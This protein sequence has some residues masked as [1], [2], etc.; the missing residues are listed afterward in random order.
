MASKEY[1]IWC[2]ESIKKGEFY[3]N[4]YGGVLIQSK[5]VQFVN[6]ALKKIVDEIKITEEIKWGK[7]DGV[8]LKAF[9]TLMDVFFKLVQKN[10]IKVRIMFRQNAKV[11]KNL[12]QQ[13]IENEFFLLYYQFIKHAFGLQYSNTTKS[14]IHV[15]VHFDNLPDTISKAQQFKDYIKGL[16]RVKSFLD[17]KIKFRKEGIVEVDSKLHLPLQFLDVVLGSMQFRL[18]DKHKEKP[19]GK[20]RRG[21]RTIAKE[22]LYKHINKKIRE[23]RKGF[24]VGVSTGLANL[25]ERWEHPYRHWSF[26]PK[27]FE[28]EETLNK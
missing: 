10:K 26:T 24:N 2:D 11:A 16:E 25:N 15:R 6:T 13:H 22:K 28:I 7:V 23:T 4:F 18:N 8:K 5:D 12:Q 3:S 9:I 20:S 19:L 21:K 27:E 14:P 1:F 17:A